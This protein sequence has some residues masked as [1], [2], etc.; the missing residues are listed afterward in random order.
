MGPTQLF[1]FFAQYRLTNA[2]LYAAYTI[3]LLF[4]VFFVTKACLHGTC[5]IVLAIST[6]SV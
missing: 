3:I 6:V 1:W 2:R 4:A 5:K